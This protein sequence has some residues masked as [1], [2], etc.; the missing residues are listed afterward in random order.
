MA[1]LLNFHK[2]QPNLTIVSVS[3]HPNLG[4]QADQIVVLDQGAIVEHGQYDE[5]AASD[6]H[7][8]ALL[9]GTTEPEGLE[10]T[11]ENSHGWLGL[12]DH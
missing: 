11:L 10:D 7:F 2:V 6:G 8:S 1:T 3:H 12:H 5:L 4:K 9:K